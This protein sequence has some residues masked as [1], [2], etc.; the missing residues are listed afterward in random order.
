[1]PIERLRQM[2][3]GAIDL[4][5][6]RD[7]D[8]TAEPLEIAVC[9]QHNNGGLAGNHW[10]ESVNVKH[11]FPVGEVNGSHGVYRPGGAALNSGQVGGL[12]AAQFISAKYSGNPKTP[13]EFLDKISG[14]LEK[15]IELIRDLVERSKP[16]SVDIETIRGE[17]QDRMTKYGAHIRSGNGVARATAEARRL[18]EYLPRTLTIS[19]RDELPGA[20]RLIHLAKTHLVY[21]EAMREYIDRGGGSRGSSLVLDHDGVLPCPGFREEWSYRPFCGSF[22]GRICE[23]TIEDGEIVHRWLDT[24]PIPVEPGWFEQIWREYRD[25][26]FD[27][28]DANVK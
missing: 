20:L 14:V 12:R 19:S 7:I 9:A 18:C 16:G 25:G 23:T 24:R 6:E 26:G 27:W 13:G 15:K 21:L 11:L 5:R 1:T 2:N 8:V 4:Y 3:P 17:I 28:A 22:F 10:W